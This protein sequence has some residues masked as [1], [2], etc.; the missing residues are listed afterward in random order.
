MIWKGKYTRQGRPIKTLKECYNDAS[1]ACYNYEPVDESELMRVVD[2]SHSLGMRVIPYMSPFYS[3]AKGK[4]FV[5]KVKEMLGKF[6][7]DGVY[8]DGVS[9]DILYSYRM[10]REIRE[11]LGD[12]IL[13]VHCT[14]DPLMSTTIYCPFI[15]TYA[16]YILRAEHIKSFTDEYLRYVISG[17]NISNSIGYICYYD[18]PINFIKSLIEKAL[19]FNVRFYLGL[20][21]KEREKLLIREYFPRLRQKA[22]KMG[23]AF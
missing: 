12:K 9:S 14:S 23:F 17:Y 11:V 22:E 2:T 3:S 19:T 6:R 5:E 16:D 18:Y 20:P 8:F 1:W 13:Y 7:M 15:D 21:M 10:V 4:Y